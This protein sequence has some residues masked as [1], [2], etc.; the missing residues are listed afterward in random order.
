MR[1]D[2]ANTFVRVS[3][4]HPSEL[5]GSIAGLALLAAG[6]WTLWRLHRVDPGGDHE[7]LTL[8]LGCL[9][10]LTCLYHVPYDE[11]LLVGP[12]VLLARRAPVHEIAWP[13]RT[14]VVVFVL[15]LIP[16][17]DPLGWSPINAVLG[18]SGFEWML[19]PTMLSLD[20]LAAP[21]L[22]L[23]TGFRQI[24]TRGTVAPASPI[25]AQT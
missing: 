13:R 8:T 6:A 2:A 5:V 1:I 25:S 20:V 3:H 19:G 7:E 4:L 11:L 15:L 16:L 14:R 23:W 18:K 12:M 24:R 17:V 21:G 10:I 22:C 9:L